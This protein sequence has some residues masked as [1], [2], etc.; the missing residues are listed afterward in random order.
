MH[1]PNDFER[2]ILG[3]NQSLAPQNG[4]AF[5]EEEDLRAFLET[6]TELYVPGMLVV[7]KLCKLEVVATI[8]GAVGVGVGRATGPGT[9]GRPARQC[10]RP[11]AADQPGLD[12]HGVR[13]VLIPDR[14]SP[15][16]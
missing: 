5:H 15:D 13:S 9:A 7:E 2:S 16:A 1:T 11:H 14:L 4:A 6:P 3:Y 8:S 10:A 12:R